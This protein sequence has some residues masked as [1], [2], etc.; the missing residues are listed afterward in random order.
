MDSFHNRSLNETGIELSSSGSVTD[1]TLTWSVAAKIG[2]LVGL[3][4]V[5]VT[6]N[7]LV[8]VA[9]VRVAAL[10]KVTNFF[11]VS[12]ASADLLMGVFTI[13]LF[14]VWM[15]RQDMFAASVSCNVV[16]LSCLFVSVSSQANVIVVTAERYCAV[17]HPFQHR[18]LFFSRP[19]VVRK[20]I[21]AVWILSGVFSGL[22]IMAVNKERATCSY[23]D[24]FDKNFL[25]VSVILG[26]FV[27]F[28]VICGLNVRILYKVHNSGLFQRDM[29]QAC[30][31]RR[32]S[33]VTLSSKATKMVLIVCF[34]FLLGWTPFFIVVVVHSFC[35]TC[36]LRQALDLILLFAFTNSAWNP[37]IYG[38]C[39]KMFRR[40][41]KRVLTFQLSRADSSSREA[42][43]VLVCG[44][45]SI[46]F[47][48]Q[49]AENTC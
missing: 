19:D 16:L 42:K 39:N 30:K 37:M 43:F 40:A 26:V 49:C 18:R 34:L 5:V 14:I 2:Y 4:L 36:H 8:I 27:P 31:Q 35:P 20:T 47:D 7:S 6:G 38:L 48:S 41:Y 12:L 10:H 13:P 29:Y 24:Y 25:L 22:S 15:L 32:N 23:Y 33:I 44:K 3:S 1:V 46:S 28:A 45:P 21:C 9:V 17:C 11:L